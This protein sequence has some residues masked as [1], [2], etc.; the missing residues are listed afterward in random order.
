M[1]AGAVLVVGS[2]VGLTSNFTGSK[3]STD[4]DGLSVTFARQGHV[5]TTKDGL[6]YA[7]RPATEFRAQSCDLSPDDTA[8]LPASGQLAVPS[9]S[10]EV[11]VGASANLSDLPDAPQVVQFDESVAL[12]SEQGKTVIAGHVDYTPN[13]L[14]LGATKLSPF[15]QLH[16][17]SPCDHIYAADA[18][19]V[20][21]EYVLTDMYTVPQEQIEETGIYA[22]TGA[23]ALVLVTCSGP[24]VSDARG[25]D[26]FAYRYNLVLEAAPVE[27]AP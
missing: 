21:H 20:Q 25:D 26:L 17:A 7:P 1:A 3:T 18:D 10:V 8:T 24:S 11:P 9:I 6:A 13:P 27:V 16:T 14:D 19:G 22:T 2:C 15:G 4:Q 23:P 5:G 12:G